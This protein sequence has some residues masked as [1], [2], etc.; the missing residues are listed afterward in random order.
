[1]FSLFKKK[2]DK[3]K[4]EVEIKKVAM[5]PLNYSSKIILAWSKALEGNKEISSW[6]K[7]NGFEELVFASAAIYLKDDARKWLMENGFPH[8]MAMIN[9]AEGDEKAQKWL[10]LNNFN[11]L[12]HLALAIEDEKESWIWLKQNT[13]ADIIILAQTIK[14]IK[15]GIE[16]NH[17]DIHYFGRD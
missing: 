14:K 8:L 7:D 13:S 9:A 1:M 15:D 12:Y 16:E 11:L 6:L 5:K 3:P 10:K 2:E 17:N 4:S